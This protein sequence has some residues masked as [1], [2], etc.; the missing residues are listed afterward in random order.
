[1]E[2]DNVVVDEAYRSKGVGK[3]LMTWMYAEAKKLKCTTI[4]LDAYV[5]NGFG[6]KFYFRE[7]FV[8]K[9]FHFLKKIW[10]YTE[11]GFLISYNAPILYFFKFAPSI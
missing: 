8:I 4:I 11:R 6:H 10:F 5:E 2:P 3:L 1:M 9:G 7:G